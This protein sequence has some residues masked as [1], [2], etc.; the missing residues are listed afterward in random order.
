MVPPIGILARWMG[1]FIEIV[2]RLCGG[3]HGGVGMLAVVG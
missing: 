3:D 2:E 1:M